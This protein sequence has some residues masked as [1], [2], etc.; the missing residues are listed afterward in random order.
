[1]KQTPKTIYNKDRVVICLTGRHAGKKAII[2]R[3]HEEGTKDRPYS[4]LVITGIDRYPKKITKDMGKTKVEKKS[5]FSIFVKT[6]NSN[7]VMPTRYCTKLDVDLRKVD[8]KVLS[9][10]RNRRKLKVQIK[11]VLTKKYLMFLIF[12]IFYRFHSTQSKYMF[13]KLRF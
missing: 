5:R 10:H 1:M 2:L 11:S 3:S 13:K 12:V 7:H 8:S 6:V 9:S 4:H